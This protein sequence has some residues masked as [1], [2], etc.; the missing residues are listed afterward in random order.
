MGGRTYPL[1]RK[2][3]RMNESFMSLFIYL[4]PLLC[5]QNLRRRIV[6]AG[7]SASDYMRAD[8]NVAIVAEGKGWDTDMEE[9][10]TE[11]PDLRGVSRENLR[12]FPESA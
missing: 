5:T 2:Q 11:N 9:A 4:F 8:A 12:V 6:A 3:C 1:L 7:G 10:A